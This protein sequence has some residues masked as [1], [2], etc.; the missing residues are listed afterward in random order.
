MI[1]AGAISLGVPAS[2]IRGMI[3]E[4]RRFTLYGFEM[5]RLG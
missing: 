2:P 1:A 3:L 4:E 5:A